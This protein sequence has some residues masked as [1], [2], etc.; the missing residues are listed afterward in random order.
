MK[1][2][3]WKAF[4]LPLHYLEVIDQ[5]LLS[6][7]LVQFLFSEFLFYI[8]MFFMLRIFQLLWPSRATITSLFHGFLRLLS[9]SSYRR[10]KRAK[11][12]RLKEKW[13]N[14]KEKMKW[15]GEFT[16]RSDPWAG[17]IA[18]CGSFLP[19]V[20]ALSILITTFLSKR[21]LF[22]SVT[23]FKPVHAFLNFL[24]FSFLFCKPGIN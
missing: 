5:Q 22:P 20:Q 2:D 8:Q 16:L 9:L 4:G 1:Q 13:C 19:M 21:Q 18:S 7:H 3:F 11:D 17:L 10:S 15:E 6:L 24:S 14:V 23:V 12:T